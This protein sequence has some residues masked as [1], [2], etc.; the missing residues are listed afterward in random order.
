MPQIVSNF[1]GHV[2]FEFLFN[3]VNL[4]YLLTIAASFH[5][6]IEEILLLE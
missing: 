2:Q 6:L 4:Y 5:D 3:K 1:L